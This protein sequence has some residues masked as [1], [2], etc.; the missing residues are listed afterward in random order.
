M[1]KDGVLT[2]DDQKIL[3]SS[4]VAQRLCLID[5]S[6]L[7]ISGSGVDVFPGEATHLNM[8]L[9]MLMILLQW[10]KWA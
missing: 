2:S 7:V 3:V 8:L 5:K 6:C 10:G 4:K 9:Q 1:S